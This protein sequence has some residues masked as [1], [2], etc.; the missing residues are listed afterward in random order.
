MH[1][2]LPDPLAV[3]H[4]HRDDILARVVP[5]ERDPDTVA[6]AHDGVD[7]VP[8]ADP[9]QELGGVDADAHACPN[10]LVLCR[11]LLDVDLYAVFSAEVVQR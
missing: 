11:L 3:V 10:F 4:W 1:R 8:D 2:T 7:G 6:M 5:P 9:V